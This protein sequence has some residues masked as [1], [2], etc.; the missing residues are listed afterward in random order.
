[1]ARDEAGFKALIEPMIMD[2]YLDTQ[3]EIQC[4]ARAAG[5]GLSGPDAEAIVLQTCTAHGATLERLAKTE[6]RR[7]I[8]TAVEDKFLD[9]G[10]FDDLERRGLELFEGAESPTA[11]VDDLINEVLRR[12]KATTEK[13]VEQDV[14]RVLDGMKIQ[15]PWITPDEWRHV[16]SQQLN[17]L[18]D[19]GVDL[20]ENDETLRAILDRA[21][22]QSGLRVRNKTPVAL[23]AIPVVLV[24]AA[25]GYFLFSGG[26]GDAD[27]T[28]TKGAVAA[29][30]A[31]PAKTPVAATPA[32]PQ[33]KLPACDD[34]CT[35][36]LRT[37]NQRVSEAARSRRYVTP[38]E[39]CVQKWYGD[40]R[41]R[42]QPYTNLSPAARK[43][44]IAASAGWG[45]CT[46]ET[47]VLDQIE[48]NY[49]RWASERKGKHP[50]CEWLSRCLQVMPGNEAC[51]AERKRQGCPN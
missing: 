32:P 14:A 3:E 26:G 50:P 10:E 6:F 39:N 29:P 45:W 43:H 11:I 12:E 37:T 38:A 34:A 15:R 8:S 9:A 51:G 24:L 28:A 5:F 41:N 13:H 31:S 18:A 17:R 49:M 36:E 21:L 46:V 40:L 1:M 48:T 4:M 33:P 7:E 44:A 35:K 20:E 2:G 22:A 27:G 19:L 23:I 25:A 42:C 47:E 30:A 16:Q